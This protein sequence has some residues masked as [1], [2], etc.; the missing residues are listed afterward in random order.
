MSLPIHQ[1]PKVKKLTRL[2]TQ[3]LFKI[4]QRRICYYSLM[5]SM[6]LYLLLYYT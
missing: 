4:K 5:L 2:V 1:P 3:I 6:S